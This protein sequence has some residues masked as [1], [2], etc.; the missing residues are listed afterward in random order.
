MQPLLLLAFQ[1]DDGNLLQTLGLVLLVL[2]LHLLGVL[3]FKTPT[4]DVIGLSDGQLTALTSA[5]A[6]QLA[7]AKADQRASLLLDS[8]GEGIFGVDLQGQVAFINPAAC[9]MLGYESDDLIGK[10]V[11]ERIH[12]SHLATQSKNDSP[13]PILLTLP[14]YARR[15]DV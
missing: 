4:L 15:G 1:T 6:T 7:Q 2:F 14:K 12:H 13:F 5:D 8:A 11:H 3:F 10:E 9:R